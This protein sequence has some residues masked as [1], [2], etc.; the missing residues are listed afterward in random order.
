MPEKIRMVVAG[1]GS[2]GREHLRVLAGMG[3][4]EI[5]GV[6]D[7]DLA[8]ASE[9][10]A[11]YGAGAVAS[12]T[13]DLIDRLAPDGL[14]VASPGATHVRLACAALERGFPVLVEKPVAMSVAEV[15]ALTV[16]EAASRAF[17][18]P[19]HILRF[20]EHH[21]LFREIAQSPEVGPI[22]GLSARRYRDDSHA[23]R[24]A[25]VDPVLMTMVHDIDLALWIT[26]A[27]ATEVFA[28]RRPADTPR[29]VTEM[30]ACDNKGAVWQLATAWTYPTLETPPDRIAVVGE[31]GG[32]ELE[33]GTHIRQYGRK[34]RLID[35][36]SD[37]PEDP[38]AAELR[39]FVACIRSG[40][41][42]SVVTLKDACAGLGIAD[43][44]M[45]SLRSGDKVLL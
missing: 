31:Q 32:V 5:A 7:I 22:L 14:I 30:L 40:E 39:Y 43:A 29:S 6:A 2:F 16:A 12:E 37:P 25:D 18:L 33:A 9:A 45:A 11:R 35:L 21:R 23:T 20:S 4:V 41:R 34:P 15:R 28:I 27:A 1:A 3:D 26:G 38:L 24:Y 36:A 19:G 44:V 17:V 10:A 8:A 42:P 13:I